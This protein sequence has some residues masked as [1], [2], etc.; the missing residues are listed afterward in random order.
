MLWVS[1]VWMRLRRPNY[2]GR[3]LP[4]AAGLLFP[5]VGL[6]G[7]WLA[8]IGHPVRSAGFLTLGAFGLLGLLDDLLGARHRARGLRGHLLALVRGRITTGVVKAVGGLAAGL[9][10]GALLHPGHPG[11]IAADAVLIALSANLVNLLDLRPGRALK[12]FFLLCLPALAL[13]PESICL[14]A[15]LLA[16]AALSAPADLAGRTMMGDVGSNTLGA[17]VGLALALSLGPAG[18]AGAILLLLALHLLSERVSLTD[19]IARSR[20]L[21]YLDRLGTA[22]LPPLPAAREV[23]P[24]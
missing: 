11:L 16:A 12:G 3:N 8:P 21:G 24:T 18:R 15:P 2:L 1:A 13:S 19:L 6:L 22:H 9:A 4:A 20:V 5:A 7:L 17:A 23:V 10:A 14:L